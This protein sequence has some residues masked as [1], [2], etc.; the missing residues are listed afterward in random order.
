MLMDITDDFMDK[1]YAKFRRDLEFLNEFLTVK[2][3]L[4][5]PI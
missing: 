4:K 2:E 1:D 5:C 3:K